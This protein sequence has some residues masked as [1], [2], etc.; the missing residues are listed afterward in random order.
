MDGL[1]SYKKLANFIPAKAGIHEM[2][3]YADGE[4]Y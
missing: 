4:M 1:L 3:A 2:Q